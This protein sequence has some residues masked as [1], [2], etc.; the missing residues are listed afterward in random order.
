MTAVTDHQLH[1]GQQWLAQLLQVA[2]LPAAVSAQQFEVAPEPGELAPDA[3]VPSTVGWLTIGT[4]NLTPEQ[5]QILIGDRGRSLDSIQYLANLLLNLNKEP[6][7]QLPFTV[8]INNYRAARL[9]ALQNLAESAVAQVRETGSECELSGLSSAERRQVH[10]LLKAWSEVESF[11]RG[12][13]PDRRLVVCPRS[14]V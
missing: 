10:T 9:E 2:G 14:A 7:E 11:S 3:I 12:M 8:D 5:V 13:E 4:E 6:E 1:Q